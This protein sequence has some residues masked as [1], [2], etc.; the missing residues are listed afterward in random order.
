MKRSL[1]ILLA[2]IGLSAC[3]ATASNQPA[4]VVV[5]LTPANASGTCVNASPDPANIRAGQSIAFR[6]STSVSHTV[7]ADGLDM[8]WTV[9]A[10][11]ELSGAIKLSI[12]SSRKYY[13]QS[14]GSAAGNLHTVVVTVN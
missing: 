7:I 3:D 13:V 2:F 4:S 5:T 6:N 1:P 10:P 9:V 8:P 12:A 14:C 11:G